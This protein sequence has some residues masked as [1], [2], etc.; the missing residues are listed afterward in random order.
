MGG[1]LETGIDRIIVAEKLPKDVLFCAKSDL[2]TK[3][4][5]LFSSMYAWGLY[6]GRRETADI[7]GSIFTTDTFSYG[8]SFSLVLIRFSCVNMTRKKRRWFLTV[9]WLIR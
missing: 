1:I 4:A 9:K 3:D 5:V 2:V 8:F 7:R 6:T